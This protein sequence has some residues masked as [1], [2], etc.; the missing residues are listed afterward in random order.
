[1][2]YSVQRFLVILN[3]IALKRK[4]EGIYELFFINIVI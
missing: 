2:M 1:M 3:I 4:Y